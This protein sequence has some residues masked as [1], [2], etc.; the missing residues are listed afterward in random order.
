MLINLPFKIESQI[1][2]ALFRAVRARPGSAPYISG[3]SFRLL[4]DHRFEQGH[5]SGFDPARVAEGD[6]VYC[7]A[8]L[9]KQ[10]LSGA[11][12]TV[13]N[14]FKLLT[15]NGDLNVDAATAGL[16]PENVS[17]WFAQNVCIDHPRV[18][19][20]PI[21]LENLRF[22]SNGIV[23]DFEALR[24]KYSESSKMNRIMYG[25]TAGTNTRERM[26]C[27]EAL[28]K[29]ALA[30]PCERTNSR[31]YLR[32]LSHYRF[33]ASPPGNE[34]TATGHGRRC[35]CAWYPSSSVPRA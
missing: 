5:E 21:G 6:L 12:S 20:I 31:N 1:R 28:H 24:K 27:I 29:T 26:P 3:D 4:A 33:V 19:P 35:T 11:G 16:L 30:D 9:V 14:A 22:H 18:I 34:K 15:H 23:G 25:F 10:F 13:A 17:R 7:E 2:R 32:V 8:G